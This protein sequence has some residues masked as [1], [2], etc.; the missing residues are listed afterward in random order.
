MAEK[1]T[2]EEL[3]EK[4]RTGAVTY[5]EVMALLRAGDPAADDAMSEYTES[6]LRIA[7]KRLSQQAMRKTGADGVV[8]SV[9]QSLFAHHAGPIDLQSDQSLWD[10]LLE[11]TLRH[12]GKWNKRYRNPDRVEAS[13]HPRSEEGSPGID[14]G[15]DGP[16]PE[17]AVILDDWVEKLRGAL[18]TDLQRKVFEL[19]L[20][21]ESPAEIAK[22]LQLSQATIYQTIYKIRDIVGRHMSEPEA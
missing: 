22:Q 5:A 7:H 4:L 16:T 1:M 2:R 8:Q 9:L 12:C 10:K 21:G 6:L 13:L 11:I 17:E 19:R 20:A 15:D 3:K 18:Q 14:P